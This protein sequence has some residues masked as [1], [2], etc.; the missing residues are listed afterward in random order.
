MGN[1]INQG[2]VLILEK[3]YIP[4]IWI[5]NYDKKLSLIEHT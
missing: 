1:K 2:I 3:T 4:E 5:Y